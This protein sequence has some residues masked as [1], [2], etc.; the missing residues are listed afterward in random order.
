M[1]RRPLVGCCYC[2]KERA[3]KEHISLIRVRQGS[4]S[5]QIKE[6]RLDSE[7][8]IKEV[9]RHEDIKSKKQS[10]G[11]VLIYKKRKRARESGNSKYILYKMVLCGGRVSLCLV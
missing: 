9:K 10:G 6:E 8:D 3:F 11:K 4:S 5:M 2:T 7:A 1:R